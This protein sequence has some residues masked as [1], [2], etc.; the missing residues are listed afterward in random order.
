VRLKDV[1]WSAICAPIRSFDAPAPGKPQGAQK[2]GEPER[3]AKAG[4][5]ASTYPP[6][7][8]LNGSAYRP[9]NIPVPSGRRIATYEEIKRGRSEGPTRLNVKAL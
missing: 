9:N 5:H 4:L 8:H 3:V 2:K 6:A 1:P 7:T